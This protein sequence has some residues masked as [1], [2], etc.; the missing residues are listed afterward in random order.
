[1]PITISHLFFNRQENY[2]ANET[3]IPQTSQ[4][5]YVIYFTNM[6]LKGNMNT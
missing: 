5:I 6:F 1:M 2:H 4:I 3:S